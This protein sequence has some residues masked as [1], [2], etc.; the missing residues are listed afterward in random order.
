MFDDFYMPYDFGYSSYDR[1]DVVSDY[2][3]YSLSDDYPYFAD[4]GAWSDHSFDAGASAFDLAGPAGADAQTLWPSDQEQSFVFADASP[5]LTDTSST[6]PSPAT[7]SS[8]PYQD[9]ASVP[10]Y[11]AAPVTDAYTYS[12]LSAT[13]NPYPSSWQ[14]H[15]YQVTGAETYASRDSA[16]TALLTNPAPYVHAPTGVQTYD[17]STVPVLGNVTHY[18]NPATGTLFNVTEPSH[19]L[20]PGFVMRDVVQTDA[21]QFAIRTTGEGSGFPWGMNGSLAPWVWDGR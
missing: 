19:L 10:F 5:F 2:E 11:S 21:G 20:S 17:V 4:A 3:T 12:Y 16:Q 8:Q 7:A 9:F 6:S 1:Y 13:T 15:V 14:S 18:V